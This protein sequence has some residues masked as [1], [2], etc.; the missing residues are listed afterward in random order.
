[1][2]LNLNVVLEKR[3]FTNKIEGDKK[4]P[5]G[6]YELGPLYFRKDRKT[7]PKTKLKIFEI[8][9]IWAGVMI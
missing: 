4:T 1:M 7:K 8:K 6:N 5:I 9:K 2:I 3:I